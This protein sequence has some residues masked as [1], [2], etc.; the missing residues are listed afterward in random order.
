MLKTYATFY[1]GNL[2]YV[3]RTMSKQGVL[4]RAYK[5]DFRVA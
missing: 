3:G 5:A 1:V 4:S 2:K